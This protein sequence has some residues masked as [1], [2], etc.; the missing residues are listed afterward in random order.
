MQYNINVANGTGMEVRTNLNLAH[1][2][3]ATN[4]FGATDPSLMSPVCA[5]PGSTWADTGNGLLKV[6]KAD[7]SDWIVIGTIESDG[8]PKLGKTAINTSEL[9]LLP[10]SGGTMTGDIKLSS[11]VGITSSVNNSSVTLIGGNRINPPSGHENG[12]FLQLYGKD[13]ANRA[14][15]ATIYA[16][17]GTQRVSLILQPDGTATWKGIPLE[18][19]GMPSTTKITLNVPKDTTWVEREYTAA[20]DGY[21]RAYLSGGGITYVT[22]QGQMQIQG[23][24]SYTQNIFV[25]VN[26]G[27]YKIACFVSDWTNRSISWFFVPTRGSL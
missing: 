14:G 5:F 3:L 4:F 27:T 15:W 16:D 26:K 2:S 25:P 19:L 24:S 23:N 9:A 12:A 1:Q 22:R 6:R 8:T 20:T 10:L 7:N 17:N 21:L 18:G 13:F 11:G